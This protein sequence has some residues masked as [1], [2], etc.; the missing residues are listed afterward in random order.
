MRE[1]S[2]SF[3]G[4]RALDRVGFV[5]AA[6]EML[7]LIGPNGAGKTTLFNLINGQLRPDA[8]EIFFEEK[9][10]QGHSPRERCR[11][12]I[13]R[14]FQ[15]AAT[16][17]SMNVR[18]NVQRHP[19][20]RR[21]LIPFS[22]L[23]DCKGKGQGSWSNSAW[24]RKA[25]P[26]AKCLRRPEGVELRWRSPSPALRGW[27][28]RRRAWRGGGGRHARMDR[29]KKIAKEKECRLFRSTT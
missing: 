7:A 11:L 13:G 26:C 24:T 4:V 27:T 10:I 29:V 28:S 23:K 19:L 9:D 14:T 20:E 3:G 8:G 15:V 6:G 21:G 16:F 18:Q 2:K 1:L 12:G 25:T 17:G 5:L 22:S